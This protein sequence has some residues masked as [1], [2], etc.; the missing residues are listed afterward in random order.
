MWT[1][2]ILFSTVQSFQKTPKTPHYSVTWGKVANVVFYVLKINSG[3][4]FL[5]LPKVMG[6]F[7]DNLWGSDTGVAEHCPYFPL[8]LSFSFNISIM[9]KTQSS[10]FTSGA[11]LIM[12]SF[13]FFHESIN[14]HI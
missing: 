6:F 13:F 14:S 1:S 8:F 2:V 4:S 7:A 3:S 5:L 9:L 11:S 12:H 10:Y